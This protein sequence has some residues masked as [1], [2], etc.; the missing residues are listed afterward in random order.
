MKTFL[1][2]MLVVV[3]IVFL[4][5]LFVMWF[6][7]DN[8][9]FEE[10]KI[11]QVEKPTDNWELYKAISDVEDYIEWLNEDLFQGN[12]T[13]EYHDVMLE[14]YENTLKCLKGM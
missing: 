9:P 7:V 11:H 3:P 14:N 6:V 13:Q 12:I 8:N 1:K 5:N 2:F 4:Q 10:P